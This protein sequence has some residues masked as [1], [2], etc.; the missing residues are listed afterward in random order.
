[1]R[2]VTKLFTEHPDT[3]GETYLQH[4]AASFG[5]SMRLLGAS[6]ACLVHA[7]FPFWH[8]STGSKTITQLHDNMVTHRDKRNAPKPL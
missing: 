8:V 1:M 7:L 5:F 6:L 3:V 4:M 2:P